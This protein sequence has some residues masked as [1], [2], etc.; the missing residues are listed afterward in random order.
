MNGRTI[1][2]RRPTSPGLVATRTDDALTCQGRA[3]SR[4]AAEGTSAQAGPGACASGPTCR[5]A[6]EQKG[7]DSARRR[8]CGRTLTTGCPSGP[9]SCS[10]KW[11]GGKEVRSSQ[12]G[13]PGPTHQTETW[14]RRHSTEAVCGGWGRSWRH[15]G[16]LRLPPPRLLSYHPLRGAGACLRLRGLACLPIARSESSEPLSTLNSEQQKRRAGRVS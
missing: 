2:Q 1:S 4:R 3:R 8:G 9:M 13:P 14:A 11:P 7:S 16:R 6:A 5:I 12:P 10:M 15:P